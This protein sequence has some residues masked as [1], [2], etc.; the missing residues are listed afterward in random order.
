[1]NYPLESVA[2]TQSCLSPW[3]G[4]EMDMSAWY[5]DSFWKVDSPTQTADGLSK[6]ELVMLILT[7]A[8]LIAGMNGRK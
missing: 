2:C 8:A 6:S 4:L 3:S 5:T 1:M 7:I